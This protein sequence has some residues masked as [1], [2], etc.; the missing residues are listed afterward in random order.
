MCEWLFECS[1]SALNMAN[2]NGGNLHVEAFF[3]GSANSGSKQR[4]GRVSRD[5]TDERT[6]HRAHHIGVKIS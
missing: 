6:G 5:G 3:N 1:F 4:R 2:Q